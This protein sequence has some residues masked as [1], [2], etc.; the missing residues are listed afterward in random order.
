MVG[1]R[2]EQAGSRPGWERAGADQAGSG[3]EQTGAGREQREQAGQAGSGREHTR[4][5]VGGSRPGWERAGAYQAGSGWE[6]TGARREQTRQRV[7]GSRPEQAG[8]RG[9][10]PD[11]LEVGGGRQGL[12]ERR[13]EMPGAYRGADRERTGAEREWAADI[14][15]VGVGYK[16]RE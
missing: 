7:C 14:G 6:Q 11:R 1:S 9:S 13:P 5:V 3:R 4:Q 12:G 15:R 16:N 2:P 10:R 8:S